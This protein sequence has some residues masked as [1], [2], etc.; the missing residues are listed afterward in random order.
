MPVLAA[1][2]GTGPDR[3]VV[4]VGLRTDGQPGLEAVIAGSASP[5]PVTPT[6]GVSFTLTAHAPAPFTVV[7][8]AT[9]P[10]R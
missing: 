4:L 5:V 10:A 2:A 3:L 7:L 8:P 6:P 9:G 1:Q